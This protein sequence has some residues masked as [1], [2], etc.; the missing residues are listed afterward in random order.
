MG[1]YDVLHDKAK[2]WLAERLREKGH[3]VVLEQRMNHEVIFDV[4]DRTEQTAWEVLTAKIVRSSHEQDE[5]IIAKIFRYLLWVKNLKFLLVSYDH[6]ELDFF[7]TMGIEHWHLSSTSWWK[8]SFG[9]LFYHRG[10]NPKEVAV[11]LVREMLKFAGL[12]EWVGKQRGKAHRKQPIPQQFDKLTKALGLPK[13]FLKGMWRDWR[14]MWVW[15]LEK[16]LP[17]F[18]KRIMKK[19]VKISSRIG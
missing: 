11:R 8:P 9:K 3:S 18:V 10:K 5:A 17:V 16:I 4:Y 2:E 6:E 15:K 14:L 12:E 19:P 7:H 13:N 1:W